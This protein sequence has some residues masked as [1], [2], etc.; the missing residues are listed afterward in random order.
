MDPLVDAAIEA[1]PERNHPAGA[2]PHNEIEQIGDPPAAHLRA[3][4][5][6]MVRVGTRTA[7]GGRTSTRG[8][9]QKK[10]G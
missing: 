6:R 9:K 10:R 8:G 2:A 3:P 1:E 4:E 7:I 5:G